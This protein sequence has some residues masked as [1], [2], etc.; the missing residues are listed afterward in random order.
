MFYTDDPHADFDR[1]DREQ[2]ESLKKLPVCEK[3]GQPIQSEELYDI[4]GFLYCEKC[5]D[6]LFK[7]YTENYIIS[8]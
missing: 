7:R 6:S 4:E 5:G 8:E 1:H 3:C 2:T